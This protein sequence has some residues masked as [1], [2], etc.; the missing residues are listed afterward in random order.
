MSQCLRYRKE[1]N[2]RVEVAGTDEGTAHITDQGTV[3]VTYRRTNIE[4]REVK[5]DISENGTSLEVPSLH[6][7]YEIDSTQEE[8]TKVSVK[9]METKAMVDCIPLTSNK[10][11][12]YCIPLTSDKQGRYGMSTS[13]DG[14]DLVVANFATRR[15]FIIDDISDTEQRHQVSATIP[16]KEEGA[17]EQSG[18]VREE[19]AGEQSGSVREEGAG[20]QSGSVREEGAGEQSGVKKG[21]RKKKII[22]AIS[23]IAVIV[24]LV[25]L[26][27]IIIFVVLAAAFGGS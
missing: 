3:A 13:K 27:V 14:R 8:G 6:R 9:N 5:V 17:G 24:V 11:G 25:V 4:T 2:V 12:C 10:Q 22:I 20:E 1:Q 21:K 19:G 16:I 23:V 15:I 26:V 18:S 7:L